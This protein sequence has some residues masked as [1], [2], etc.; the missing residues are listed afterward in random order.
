MN[1][2][3]LEVFHGHP[4]GIGDLPIINVELCGERMEAA[5]DVAAVR[6]QPTQKK[7]RGTI[8]NTIRGFRSVAVGHRQKHLAQ[9]E[10]GSHIRTAEIHV[11]LMSECEDTSEFSLD[12]R[13][14]KHLP[15]LPD[16]Y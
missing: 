7:E 15:P 12:T 5:D 11:V 16:D 2:L 4:Y 8:H 13:L 6:P 9:D 1:S 14:L 3:L 10:R